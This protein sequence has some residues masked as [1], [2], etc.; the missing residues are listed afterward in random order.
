M[1]LPW[2]QIAEAAQ[3]GISSTVQLGSGLVASG[4]RANKAE[5][6]MLKQDLKDRAAGKLGMSEAQQNQIAAQGMENARA[7]QAPAVEAAQRIAASSSAGGGNTAL[8]YNALGQP[9][10]NAAAAGAAARMGASNLS[11]QQA[12]QND[13]RIRGDVARAAA[14]NREGAKH[15]GQLAG[16]SATASAKTGAAAGEKQQS[17]NIATSFMGA[18]GGKK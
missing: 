1:M 7:A 12:Q 16:Q 11:T 15:Y 2:A 3:A 18:F 9:A 6:K 5:R 13:A 14:K 4:S 8:A 10:M 17:S